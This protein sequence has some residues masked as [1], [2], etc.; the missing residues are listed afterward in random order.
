MPSRQVCIMD[1]VAAMAPDHNYL[2]ILK[3]MIGSANDRLLCS[4]FLVDLLPPD[5][6][7]I[8][9]DSVLR[10]LAEAYWRGVDVRLLI[11]GSNNNYQLAKAA[12]TVRARSNQLGIPNRWLTSDDRRGS[13]MKM[14]I[15][16]NSVLTGSH[17]WSAGAFHMHVQDSIYV[18]SAEL[19]CY[20]A[21]FFETQWRRAGDD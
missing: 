10:S 15:A 9:V 13:H 3:S 2:S 5:N 6:L 21:G 7:R 12:D 11:G 16:D 1:S 17:N 19:T 18:K 4:L 20:L 8:D 14:I